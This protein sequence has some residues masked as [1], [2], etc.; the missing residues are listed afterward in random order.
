MA[1]WIDYGF[2]FLSDSVRWRFPIAFQ[3]FFTIN[4]MIGLFYLSHFPRWLAMRERHVEARDV[5][6]RL[7]GKKEDDPE[8]EQEL[9]VVKRRWTCRVRGVGL[10]LENCLRMG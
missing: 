10:S 4:V 7:L 6:A 2:Y 5:T 9:K 1:S 3:S 8:V